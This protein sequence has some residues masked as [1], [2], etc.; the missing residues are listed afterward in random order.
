MRTALITGALGFVGRKLTERLLS[1]GYKIIA[2]DVVPPSSVE[3]REGVTYIQSDLSSLDVFSGMEGCADVMYHLAWVGVKPEA[4]SDIYVQK[5]NI[6]LS[7]AAV[8]LAKRLSVPRVVFVGSTMEYC[9]N[10]GEI[11]ERSLPTPHNA[12]GSAKVAA[13][14]IAEELCRS[15]KIEFEYAVIASI[16]GKGRED[17]NVIYYCIRKLMAGETPELTE[18]VQRW[19]FV[20]IDDATEALRLIGERGKPSAFYAIG[21][22]ENKPLRECIDVISSLIDGSI[23]IKFGAV[24]YKDGLIAHSAIDITKLSRDTGYKPKHNFSEGIAE[25]IDFYRKKV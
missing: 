12:Y 9:Y 25:V 1:E 17:N 5:K 13:R 8:E 22:G 20:H 16:Y 14:F 21:T 7:I 10:E 15:Y 11:C 24:K 2:L 19:D 18:C 3:V 4:R 23:P 6:D